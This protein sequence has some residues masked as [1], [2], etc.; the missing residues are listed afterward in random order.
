MAFM[1]LA[2]RQRSVLTFSH[3]ANPMETQTGTRGRGCENLGTRAASFCSLR[4]NLVLENWF[5]LNFLFSL[6]FMTIEFWRLGKIFRPGGQ[7]N[8]F[9]SKKCS[10]SWASDLSKLKVKKIA[11]SCISQSILWPDKLY[12]YVSSHHLWRT[13]FKLFCSTGLP[14]AS[15]RWLRSTFS[16]HCP[17]SSIQCRW[18]ISAASK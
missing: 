17:L 13:N 4:W 6:I 12:R 5:G 2:F 1:S 18:L 7:K 15:T 14:L 9:K 11:L 16:S 8:Y 3:S 10:V